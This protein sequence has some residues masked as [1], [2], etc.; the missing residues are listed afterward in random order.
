MRKPTSKL[1]DNQFEQDQ[2]IWGNPIK[3]K[4]SVKLFVQ[5]PA[6]LESYGN[7][8]CHDYWSM[9]WLSGLSADQRTYDGESFKVM[10]V[11]DKS[12]GTWYNN[13]FFCCGNFV[14]C[15]LEV[16]SEKLTAV[17]RDLNV[18]DILKGEVVDQFVYR[19]SIDERMKS[20]RYA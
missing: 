11:V 1:S 2:Q 15:D 19:I 18:T 5:D 12:S 7:T 3:D 16:A 20:S 9:L 17:V 14:Y 8:H 6:G 4:L 10:N 13:L